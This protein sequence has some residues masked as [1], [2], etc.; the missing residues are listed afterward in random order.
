MR[1]NEV[2]WKYASPE[3]EKVQYEQKRSCN[4][5]DGFRHCLIKL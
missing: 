4:L 2:S 3:F 5:P 1:T